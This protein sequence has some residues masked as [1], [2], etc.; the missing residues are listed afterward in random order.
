MPMGGRWA[1]CPELTCPAVSVSWWR[2][3]R[4]R[5]RLALRQ[6]S[7]SPTSRSPSSCAP[8]TSRPGQTARRIRSG[9]TSSTACCSRLTSMRPSTMATSVSKTTDA[10]PCRRCCHPQRGPAPAH[11][12]RAARTAASARGP[13]C[14]ATAQRERASALGRLRSSLPAR[15]LGAH[16]ND[17]SRR[18]AAKGRG[19][20]V[21]QDTA[22]QIAR[23]RRHK[24]PDW[25][26]I[27]FPVPEKVGHRV[28]SHF[29]LLPSPNA[30][31]QLPP[32]RSRLHCG[33]LPASCPDGTST[34]ESP[35]AAR[36]DAASAT[37]AAVASGPRSTVTG[38]CA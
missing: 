22:S 10:S 32:M 20:E 25:F 6:C 13:R 14:H 15:W 11:H 1:A 9:W 27:L 5:R 37:D 23:S 18:A 19:S 29:A 36:K 3:G 35:W 16:T 7:P 17:D 26:G 21:G 38:R 12:A 31:R 24:D 2:S 34:T 4:G 28:Q 33:T 30:S 8:A